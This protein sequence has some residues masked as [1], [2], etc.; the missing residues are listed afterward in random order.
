MDRILSND[1]FELQLYIILLNSLNGCDVFPLNSSVTVTDSTHPLLMLGYMIVLDWVRAVALS[2][3]MQNDPWCFLGPLSNIPPAHASPSQLSGI[4]ALFSLPYW[5]GSLR[6]HNV[7]LQLVWNIQPFQVP[8]WH[9]KFFKHHIWL[10]KISM[11]T[12][13]VKFIKL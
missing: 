13:C 12:L 5:M 10:L 2:Y 1:C 9:W 3:I 8:I 6:G 7:I 4:T 11:G